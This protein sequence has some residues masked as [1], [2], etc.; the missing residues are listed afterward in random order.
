MTLHQSNLLSCHL[1]DLSAFD[2][3]QYERPK[4][5]KKIYFFCIYT[6][7]EMQ[8]LF[9]LLLKALV[10]TVINPCS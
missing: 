3:G 8:V 9:I 4:W 5:G 1:A 7:R 2:L 6:N 10:I